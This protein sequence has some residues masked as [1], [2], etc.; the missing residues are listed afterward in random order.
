MVKRAITVVIFAVVL[1]ALG[2][3]ECIMVKKVVTKLDTSVGELVTKYEANKDNVVPLLA[4]IDTIKDNWDSHENTLCLIFNHKDMSIIT[5]GLSKLR[6]Y[7][8][9][10]DYDNGIV[11]LK[12]L[13]I[14]TE[15]QPHIMG[16][17]IHNIL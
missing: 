16:F 6:T 4:D 5:D 13:K 7:T 11:E 2:L 9:N 3:T 1:F 15:K 8:E 10:N 12:L 17:N 14:N